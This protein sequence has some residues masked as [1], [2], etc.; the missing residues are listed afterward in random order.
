MQKNI[1][2]YVSRLKKMSLLELVHRI[3]ESVLYIKDCYKYQS[4]WLQSEQKVCSSKLSHQLALDLDEKRCE[5]DALYSTEYSLTILP[6][7]NEVYFKQLHLVDDFDI[8][9]YWESQRFNDLLLMALKGDCQQSISTFISNWMEFNLPLRGVNYISTMECAIRC[10]NLYATLSVLKSKN[11][12]NDDILTLSNS[13]FVVNY[14]LIRNRIS[15]F[16]SRGN[17][18]LFEYAGL[19]VCASVIVPNKQCY[20][21]DKCLKEFDC[22]TLNDGAGVEQSTAYHLFNTEVIWF[23]Q[24]YL[25][26]HISVS[27]KL[28]SALLFCADFWTDNRLVRIGDSDSSVLFSRAFIAEQLCS[29]KKNLKPKNIYSNCGIVSFRNDN[30]QCYF[31]YGSL[32][33]AP[34]FGHGH[35]DF[36]SLT[37]LDNKGQ[38]ITADAQTYLYNTNMRSQYR[39]SYYHSMPVSGKDDIKQINKFSW[40]NDATGKLLT[41]DKSWLVG[42]YTRSDG[43][44]IKR[45]SKLADDKLLVLDE[46]VGTTKCENLT[47]RWLVLNKDVQFNFYLLDKN[48]NINLLEPKKLSLD[49]SHQYGHLNKGTITE[50]TLTTDVNKKILTIITLTKNFDVAMLNNIIADI[51][52]SL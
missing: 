34:L 47:T 40:A 4:G 35:Y 36:L 48:N 21:L 20:W 3:S 16:S 31:K 15:K 45:S 44:I 46:L 49:N 11:Q 9:L 10:I 29:L 17:H 25:S 24:K 5:I 18:T 2:W 6:F 26:D 19:V 41:R 12:L 7:D 43:I 13:F 37:L 33:L 1:K 14:E 28:E 50:L 52:N 38:L 42:T 39:S 22:Q 8:R 30:L 27:K 32:G 51:N 23:I